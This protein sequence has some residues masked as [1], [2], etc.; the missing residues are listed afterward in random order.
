MGFFFDSY[1]IIEILLSNGSFKKYSNEEMTI[2]VLNLIE[3]SQYF[4]EHF[5]EEKASI[6]CKKL[7]ENIVEL[8][9]ED[10]LL[11]VKFRSENKRKSLS[12]ADCI[13][14]TYAKT[15]HLLFLTGDDAF[16]QMDNVEF[17]K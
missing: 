5:D 10:I 13:G 14:Y 15:H 17:V 8:S 7:N 3:V 4:M 11:A 16:K 12:Y 6:I 1:A 9:N 2:T